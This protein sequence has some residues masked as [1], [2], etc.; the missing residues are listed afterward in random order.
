MIISTAFL[1][2]CSGGSNSLTQT[3]KGDSTIS[4][5]QTKQALGVS[6]EVVSGTWNGLA[7]EVIFSDGIPSKTKF[8]A[9]DRTKPID[10]QVGVV[11]N[12]YV[13]GD[14]EGNR[15]KLD[16][17]VVGNKLLTIIAWRNSIGYIVEIDEKNELALAEI[18]RIESLLQ[19]GAVYRW[20]YVGSKA[21]L[22]Y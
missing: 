4:D 7:P 9:L 21:K 16:S 6:A 14:I 12:Q 13:I 2:S 10:E 17:I 1:T 11:S 5:K 3:I 22:D 19:N 15:S 18:K 20:I 8:V